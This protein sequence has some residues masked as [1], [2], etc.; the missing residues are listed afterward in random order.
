M[1]VTVDGVTYDLAV[2]EIGI[3]GFEVT[4][5][6]VCN[7]NLMQTGW[8]SVIAAVVVANGELAEPQTVLILSVLPTEE[9]AMAVGSPIIHVLFTLAHEGDSGDRDLTYALNDELHLFNEPDTAVEGDL[10]SWTI[11]GNRIRGQVTVFEYDQKRDFFA[12]PFDATCP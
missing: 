9:A 12:L 6:T 8:F 5:P 3:P 1:T 2:G 10:G 11:D 4:F 7:P